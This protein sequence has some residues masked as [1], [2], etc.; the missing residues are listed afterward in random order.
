[1]S[2][3][4]NVYNNNTLDSFATNMPFEKTV[5]FLDWKLNAILAQAICYE[6]LIIK[7]GSAEHLV[8]F[9]NIKKSIENLR[10]QNMAASTSDSQSSQS[11]VFGLIF[12]FVPWSMG[13]WSLGKFLLVSLGII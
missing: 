10:E 7:N 9:L 12:L 2:N 5:P 1:M 3:L 8:E 11:G 13:A 6:Q 4:N